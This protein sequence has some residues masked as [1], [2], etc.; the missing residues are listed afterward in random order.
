[1]CIVKGESLEIIIIYRNCQ[2]LFMFSFKPPRHIVFTEM[3]IW[4]C[5]VFMNLKNNKVFI[6]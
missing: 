6:V 5:V 4:S 2:R 1:M 3:G